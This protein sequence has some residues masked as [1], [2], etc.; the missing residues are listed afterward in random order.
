MAVRQI[1]NDID[2][3]MVGVL[4]GEELDRE[5]AEI[6]E[7]VVN[8]VNELGETALFTA[9]DKGHLDVAKELFKYSNTDTLLK[10]NLSWFDPLHKAAIQGHHGT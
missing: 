4:S 2:S 6:C 3:Q 8:E 10:K 9:A 1:L 5:V 7:S